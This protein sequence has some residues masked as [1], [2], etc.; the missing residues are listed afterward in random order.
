MFLDASCYS[1]SGAVE[2]P[3]MYAQVVDPNNVARA[4]WDSGLLGTHPGS[5]TVERRLRCYDLVMDSLTIFEEKCCNEK[6]ADAKGDAETI[7]SHAYELAFASEDEIFH[8]TL[9][10]WLIG[11]GLADDLLEVRY[12]VHRWKC[13][14][15]D[16]RCALLS[17]RHISSE[18][19]SLFKS[20]SCYGSST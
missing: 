9:Y 4:A 2:L 3:L 16:T 12:D 17:W 18:S 14:K 6:T 1:L 10:D 19:P 15:T 20:F 8:S 11:R 5:E 13:T 7:R